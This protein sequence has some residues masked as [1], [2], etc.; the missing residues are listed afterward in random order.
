M[1]KLVMIAFASIL[2]SCGSSK[3]V[4]QAQKTIKGSWNLSSI[5]Y[6]RTGTYNIK[7]LDDASK[8]CFESSTWQFIPNDYKGTYSIINTECDTGDRH[9][10]F[11]IQE[12][13]PTTGLYDFLLKPT[14][15][16]YKSE[17]NQG[18]RLKLTELSETSM[19]WQQIVNVEGRPFTIN[20]N[21]SKLE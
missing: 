14:D 6:D 12:I 15:E 9:F 13:D 21:F 3:V 11:D 5:T 1:K 8:T 19:Q 7:L 18:F 17:L 4:R 20:M 16:K 2:I 10:K